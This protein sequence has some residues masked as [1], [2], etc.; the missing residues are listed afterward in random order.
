MR[1]PPSFVK[2]AWPESSQH[3]SHSAAIESSSHNPFPLLHFIFLQPSPPKHKATFH[4]LPQPASHHTTKTLCCLCPNYCH[5]DG[6]T[7]L[8][9]CMTGLGLSIFVIHN[10]IW[11]LNIKEEIKDRLA[12]MFP[13][14]HVCGRQCYC[15]VVRSGSAFRLLKW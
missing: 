12:D 4:T 13:I 7:T 5:Y 1:T 8:C 14:F 2:M 15:F 6:L 3:F 9:F 11:P 10:S